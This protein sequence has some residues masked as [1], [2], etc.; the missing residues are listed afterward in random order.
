VPRTIE[1]VYLMGREPAEDRLVVDTWSRTVGEI[2][3][4]ILG[5]LGW[6]QPALDR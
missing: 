5:R 1:Y 4:E 6:L 3:Q 2:A